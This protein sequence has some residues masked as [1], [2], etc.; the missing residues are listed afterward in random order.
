[1]KRGERVEMMTGTPQIA[2]V[3][4]GMIGKP[5]N[6]RSGKERN[7]DILSLSPF[8][9]SLALS[10]WPAPLIAAVAIVEEPDSVTCVSELES[11]SCGGS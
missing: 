2:R 3:R 5:E 8:S 11:L 6:G 9:Q 1:M 10:Y 4:A 7:G